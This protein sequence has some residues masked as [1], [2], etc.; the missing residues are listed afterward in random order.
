MKEFFKNHKLMRALSLMLAFALT[1]TTVFANSGVTAFAWNNA[2]A[3]ADI[4][5]T[6]EIT[7]MA[8]E[9]LTVNMPNG[10][11]LQNVESS[12]DEYAK[13]EPVGNTVVVTGKS[14]GQTTITI[15]VKAKGFWNGGAKG[16]IKVNVLKNDKKSID[17]VY[18]NQGSIANDL[19]KINNNTVRYTV[20]FVT[21]DASKEEGSRSTSLSDAE[22]A[23]FIQANGISF[24]NF[25]VDAEV[26]SADDFV[27]RL[28]LVSDTYSFDNLYFYWS[29]NFD[30]TKKT[31]SGFKN[32]GR[33]SD[34]KTTGTFDNYIGYSSPELNYSDYN[35]DDYVAYQYTGVLRV[36]YI[37]DVTPDKKTVDVNYVDAAGNVIT[38]KASTVT[39]YPGR[40]ASFEVPSTVTVDDAK[41]ILKD[42]SVADGKLDV[43]VGTEDSTVNVAF[44]RV[45]NVVFENEDDTVLSS[46][47]YEAG[48][49]PVVPAAPTKA[50]D[51]AN[52]Y[53]FA[54]WDKEVAVVDG[55]ATYKATF[56]T[57]PKE[58]TIRFFKEDGTTLVNPSLNTTYHYGDTVVVPAIPAKAA[59]KTYTYEVASWD[60]QVSE[61]VVGNADYTA[62]YVPE[63]INYTVK[64]VNDDATKTVI[65]EVNNAHYGDAVVAPATNPT[66][67]SD[68]VYEYEF[69]GWK[70]EG[71]AADLTDAKVTGDLTY[72]ASFTGKKINYTVKFVNYDGTV[73]SEKT[74]YNFGDAV[75]KP[76]IPVKPSDDTY[77]YVFAGWDNEVVDVAGNATYTATYTGIYNNYTVKFVNEGEEVSSE[78]YHYGD[79]VKV[80]ANPSKTATAQYTY[81]FA[82]WKV[83]GDNGNTILAAIPAV[84]ADATYEAVFN[85]TVNEYTVTFM[86]GNTAVQTTK[87]PYGSNPEYTSTKPV[88]ASDAF[89]YVFAGWVDENK[90]SVD[91]SKVVVTEDVTFFATYTTKVV[92]EYYRYNTG[93]DTLKQFFDQNDVLG[94]D[95][96][97]FTSVDKITFTAD[98]ISAELADAL[99]LAYVKGGS[100]NRYGVKV[101]DTAGAAIVAKVVELTKTDKVTSS[102]ID[103]WYVLKRENNSWHIDGGVYNDYTVNFVSEGVEVST[104][105]YHYDDTVVVPE[106]PSKDATQEFSYEFAGWKV[107]GDNNNTVLTVIPAVT[108]DAT[109]EAVFNAI[110]NEYKITFVDEDGTTVLKEATAYPYGTKA[111]DIVKPAATKAADETYTYEFDAWTPVVADVTEDATYKASYTATY[112]DYTVKFVDEDGETLVDDTLATTYHYGDEIVAP[113]NPTKADKADGSETYTFAGWTVNGNLAE[114]A[115]TVTGDVTYVASYNTTM[116]YLVTYLNEDGT[117]L[118]ST[119]VTEGTETSATKLGVNTPSKAAFNNTEKVG[120]DYAKAFKF[121]AWVG[122]VDN[123]TKNFSAS[124]AYVVDSDKTFTAKYSALPTYFAI[125]NGD[126]DIPVEEISSQPTQNYSGK[127]SG[128]IY[129]FEKTMNKATIYDSLA[130]VPALTK[131]KWSDD[132]KLDTTTQF[133]EWYVM[134]QESDGYHIDGIIRNKPSVTYVVN[135]V[136]VSDKIYLDVEYDAESDSFKTDYTPASIA[137]VLGFDNASLLSN[138]DMASQL[139]ELFSGWMLDGNKVEGAITLT[140]AQNIVLEGT[141][142]NTYVV[143]YVS[144]E[145]NEDGSYKFLADSVST[146]LNVVVDAGEAKF[147]SPAI[148]GYHLVSEDDAEVVITEDSPL[149]TRVV[150]SRNVYTVTF[151]DE[152]DDVL[153]VVDV[154]YNDKVTTEVVPTKP[155]DNTYVYP[156]TAWED[157]NQNRYESLDDIPAITE[158]ITL[159]AVYTPVFINY[160]VTFFDRE[161]LVSYATYHYGDTLVVPADPDDYSDGASFVEFYRWSPDLQM[162]VTANAV[163]NALYNSTPLNNG[164]PARPTEVEADTDVVPTPARRSEVEAD[165][166]VVALARPARKSEVEADVK[167]GDT[168]NTGLMVTLLGFAAVALVATFATGKKKE[169]DAQ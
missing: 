80:P 8:G 65:S 123:V 118:F 20:D 142:S 153:D 161:T 16:E 95:T 154:K 56:T 76:E 125:I 146:T 155:A 14:A 84:T 135:G 26:V 83:A 38:E 28:P 55:D 124:T 3:G 78:T 137:S 88:K 32:F 115:E 35:D 132:T 62:K 9:S 52:T 143:Q 157:E 89:D 94:R 100:S 164:T 22:V 151:V 57:V 21:Y 60:K 45:Y 90:E 27:G 114:V 17:F 82:G 134:K 74:D 51:V 105:T 40:T 81:T 31:V 156:F 152:N 1:F 75:V 48:Q 79:E 71:V 63:Y 64:F 43:T 128:N 139:E 169:E 2:G 101:S 167:T 144:D 117:E 59:D 93:V 34:T 50:E 109:Y 41:Y 102:D 86:N 138:D 12:E 131:F 168:A 11:N 116:H 24:N 29:S 37:V 36:V 110:T 99:R 148:T 6:E 160:V 68:A 98:E 92:I 140:T 121:S 127:Q 70:L 30:G 133:V 136:D 49:T 46:V 72:V 107:A 19:P 7:V 61:T 106:D 130:I 39:D 87:V 54:G 129:Y 163:Y 111:E 103:V 73:I 145:R 120:T 5:F 166:D 58:F 66:K 85:S 77:R 23:E 53:T 141:L 15:S 119:R 126:R 25:T 69:A 97:L 44:A 104:E 67:S 13:G 10:Y 47:E 108:G 159:K 150:Y 96:N 122:D 4:R 149:V 33:V 42:S 147:E 162:V 113:V 18:V 158:D 91:L 165:T 112:I